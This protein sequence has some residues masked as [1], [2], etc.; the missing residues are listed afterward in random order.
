MKK[1]G[2]KWIHIFLVI[3][4]NCN[5]LHSPVKNKK[6]IIK[7]YYYSALFTYICAKNS[8]VKLYNVLVFFFIS[9]RL[10]FMYFVFAGCQKKKGSTLVEDL[11][12]TSRFNN[13]SFSDRDGVLCPWHLPH[14]SSLFYIN[15][16]LYS[17]YKTLENKI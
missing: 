14:I 16:F 8:G 13:F 2:I 3:W 17:N 7:H 5:T 15:I 9:Q 10:L 11:E 6:D 12:K 4:Q 1:Y